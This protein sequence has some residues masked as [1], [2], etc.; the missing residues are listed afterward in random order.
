MVGRR[1]AAED[2]EVHGKCDRKVHRQE[3]Q[4]SGMKCGEQR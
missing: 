2:V 4:K 3:K 1:G